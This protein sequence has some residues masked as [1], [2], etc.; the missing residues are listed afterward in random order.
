MEQVTREIEASGYTE[1]FAGETIRFIMKAVNENPDKL[2]VPENALKGLLEQLPAE[3]TDFVSVPKPLVTRPSFLDKPKEAEEPPLRVS[4]VLAEEG[5]DVPLLAAPSGGGEPS[6]PPS[7]LVPAEDGEE[8][9]EEKTGTGSGD[10]GEGIHFGEFLQPASRPQDSPVWSGAESGMDS[11]ELEEVHPEPVTLNESL[12]RQENTK[13]LAEALRVK[14]PTAPFK[15]L[16]P[17]HYRFTFINALFAGNQQA[18]AEAVDKIDSAATYDEVV[19][20]LN[21]RYAGDYNWDK[22]EDNVAI[23]FDYI[24]RKF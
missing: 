24:K 20:W 16:V 13:N 5:G 12:R 7:G 4:D 23:L 21:A 6:G 14:V 2:E 10:T 17:M 22:E 8:P 11:V 19:K 18:W 3:V 1:T 9:A 15:T